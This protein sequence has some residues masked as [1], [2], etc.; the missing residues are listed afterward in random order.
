MAHHGTVAV[1][2]SDVDV[3][4]A[5]LQAALGMTEADD[6][7]LDVYCLGI[8]TT[9]AESYL[10][11]TAVL[12]ALPDRRAAQEKALQLADDVRE[13]IPDWRGDVQ[14]HRET[15]PGGQLRR[16]IGRLVGFADKIVIATPYDS[17]QRERPLALAALDA[18]LYESGVPVI[19]VP[20]AGATIPVAPKLVSVAWDGSR[21]AMVAVRNSLP[22]LRRAGQV[23][24]IVVGPEMDW[25][26]RSDPGGELALFLAR[27]NI[28]AQVTVLANN[29]PRVA[30][31]LI[32][33][34]RESGTEAAIMGAYGHSRII[35]S[36]FGGTTRDMLEAVPV[37]LI[38]S[39]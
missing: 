25:E 38:L 27:H 36:L 39:R 2:V 10:A 14:V 21:A 11:G 19:V 20:D 12:V 15:V 37:P 5:A 26:H 8:E 30:E 9:S 3:D 29:R 1:L 18:A 31:T 32:R 24:I 4:R 17:N 7:H 33:R 13:V 16:R 34:L 35:E 28:N 23:D 22:F 6:A